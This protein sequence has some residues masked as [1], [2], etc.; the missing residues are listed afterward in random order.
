MELYSGTL[1]DVIDTAVTQ[2]RT[3]AKKDIINYLFQITKGLN[4]LHTQDPPVIH[5]D[6]KVSPVFK[7]LYPD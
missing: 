3:F 2:K 1:R 5:R 6:L 7:Y 4:Y